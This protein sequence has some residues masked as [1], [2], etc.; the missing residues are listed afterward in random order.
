M[1]SAASSSTRKTTPSRTER[2][3]TPATIP[4]ITLHDVAR[5]AGVS[6]TTVSW[7]LRGDPRIKPSTRE[8][9]LAAAQALGYVPNEVAR[10]LVKGCTNTIAIV[11]HTFSSAFESE[12]LRG[13]ELEVSE[14]HPCFTLA[15]YSASG[16]AER[17]QTLYEQLLR[18][19]KADAVISLADPPSPAIHAAYVK[20]KKP[21][22]VF[23]EDAIGMDMIHG[24]SALGAKL[25]TELLLD[26]GCRRP[27]IISS[28]TQENGRLKCNPGRV[29]TFFKLCAERGVAAQQR[30][31]HEFRFE[32]GQALAASIVAEAWD[33]VFC[34]AGDM[35]AIGIMAGCRALGV[36]IPEDLRVVGYDDL[37]VSSMV[38]PALTTIAQPLETMGREAVRLCFNA[39]AEERYTPV[40][41][42]FTPRL[43]QRDSA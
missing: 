19:N 22:V 26:R 11:S 35:V 5:A 25:A 18:G 33:G 3:T 38:Q 37:L 6:H 7:A 23:D 16:S 40:S 34:A 10:C 13:I 8:K 12:T 27:G 9:V 30:S 15:Q 36:R 1:A 21:L 2:E 32:S 31:I 41:R 43:V 28:Q 29:S 39:P 24:D 4:I 17:A 42:C 20:A 14:S